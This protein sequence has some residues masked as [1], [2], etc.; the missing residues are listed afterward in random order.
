MPIVKATPRLT[1]I[2]K[3]RNMSQEELA[4]LANVNQPFVSR[5]DKAEK[6]GIDHL[7]SIARSLDLTV[8]ELF[9]ITEINDNN[10]KETP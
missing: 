3:E 2:R 8:E 1:E 10:N 5:F 6:Y 4:K 7:I 9:H